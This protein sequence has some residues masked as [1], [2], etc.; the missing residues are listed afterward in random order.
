MNPETNSNLPYPDGFHL[1]GAE[2]WLELGSATEA[3]A[4]LERMTFHSLAQ[5]ESL[6]VRWKVFAELRRWDRA[7]EIARTLVRAGAERPTGWICLAFSL[8]NTHGAE[9]ARAQL[10]EASYTFP[11]A[12]RSVPGF[13]ARQADRLAA[14]ADPNRWLRKWERM[15]Q[16]LLNV[17]KKDAAT[18][19][20]AEAKEAVP[21]GEPA[22][23]SLDE[24]GGG[25][26]GF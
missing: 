9:H 25:R 4:D 11:E 5:P 24:A 14:S 3:L 20:D 22:G 8:I 1:S 7:L 12:S 2:G 17:Q 13:L 26:V 10:L 18:K 21:A 15:E 16:Q 6:V 23:D 19:A